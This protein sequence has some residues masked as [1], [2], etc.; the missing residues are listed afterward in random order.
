MTGW[1]VRRAIA[2][3]APAL[4][5]V[6][7]ATLLETFHAVIPAADLV[8]H[9]ANKS[10]ATSF[11]R[12][13]DDPAA[14]VFYAGADGTDAP[15]GYAVLCAPDFPIETNTADAELRRIYTLAAAHGS[16]LGPALMQAATEEAR[17]RGCRRMLLGVHP[18]NARARRFYERS[19]FCVIGE[20][21]FTVGTARFVD[22][23]YALD[24]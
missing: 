8:S 13:T 14:A 7:G 15:L 2:A 24:L 23:I 19:G 6:A 9:V 21:A 12:W 5:L 11:E 17:G 20:R 16:G 10:S 4:S 3:D 18:G 22:P 1:T